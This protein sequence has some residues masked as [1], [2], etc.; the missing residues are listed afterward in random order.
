MI[1][2]AIYQESHNPIRDPNVLSAAEKAQLDLQ[3]KN[4]NLNK[5]QLERQ[6]M[7]M[8]YRLDD[9]GKPYRDEQLIKD[10]AT[11]KQAG[12]G[13][14][15][16][17][18]TS[19]DQGTIAKDAIKITWNGD[20]DKPDFD[21]ND[22]KVERFKDDDDFVGDPIMFDNIPDKYV[23]D[24]ILEYVGNGDPYNYKYLYR[25]YK[26]GFIDDDE[27]TVI[28]IPIAKTVKD[29]DPMLDPGAH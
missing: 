12:K 5:S 2:G 11:L 29:T 22:T 10:I 17:S 18:T 9:N 1:N 8:G 4:F 21:E 16:S 25:P 24:K 19:S 13:K 7:A 14:S 28:M 23:K 6:Y 26:R 3:Q 15:G 27:Q 20:T